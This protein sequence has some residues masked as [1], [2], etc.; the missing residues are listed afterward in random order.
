M[1]SVQADGTGNVL[2]R[3]NLTGGG[4]AVFAPT[5][6]I[7]TGGPSSEHYVSSSLGLGGFPSRDVYVAAANGIIHID[8]AGLAGNQFITSRQY[9]RQQSRERSSRHSARSHRNI[10]RR[11]ARHDDSGQVYRVTS[12]GAATLLAST[13]EDTEG[14]DV[15]PLTVFGPFAGQLFVTW[16][17][18]G[19][20]RAI[21]PGGVVTVIN[22]NNL[23]AG[24]EELSFVPLNLGVSGNSVEGFYGAD[25]MPNVVKA[26]ASEFTGLLDDIIVTGEFDHL[27]TGLHWTWLRYHPYPAR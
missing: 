9:C 10:R 12:V 14:L 6:N 16:E 19:R 15:A 21:T 8:H 4:V 11:Y 26:G 23:I 1:G 20:I 22:P 5:V 3:N 2:Y 27:V 25:Y 18:S 17:G 7:P 13:G 24:A